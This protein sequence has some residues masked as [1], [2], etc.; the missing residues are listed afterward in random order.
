MFI[1]VRCYTLL[2][3][4]EEC[5]RKKQRLVYTTLEWGFKQFTAR[6]EKQELTGFLF[7]CLFVFVFVFVFVF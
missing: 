5:E 3:G 4:Y 7:V 2:E 6:P 1:G